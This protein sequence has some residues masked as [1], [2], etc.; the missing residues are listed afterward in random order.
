V[1]TEA[2]TQRPSHFAIVSACPGSASLELCTICTV[3][4]FLS[5]ANTCNYWTGDNL[6]HL[7]YVIF[8]QF[9][10]GP[11]DYSSL[12]ACRFGTLGAID[13]CMTTRTQRGNEM[14][15]GTRLTVTLERVPIYASSGTGKGKVSTREMTIKRVLDDGRLYCKT[16]NKQTYIICASLTAAWTGGRKAKFDVNALE[17]IK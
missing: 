14:I 7:Q 12:C 13:K 9:E 4:R 2:Y 11:S 1:I 10:I 8:T 17:I 6:R 5:H 3:C 16:A 15:E